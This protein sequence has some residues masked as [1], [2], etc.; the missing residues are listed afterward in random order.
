MMSSGRTGC[1][2]AIFGGGVNGCP[3]FVVKVAVAVMTEGVDNAF[4]EVV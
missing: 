1:R 3:P 2:V 4:G